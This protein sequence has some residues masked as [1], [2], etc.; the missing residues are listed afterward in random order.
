MRKKGCI[1]GYYGSVRPEKLVI[2]IKEKFGD[3]LYKAE[4]VFITYYMNKNSP[5]AMFGEIKGA[6]LMEEIEALCNKSADTML[7][8]LYDN[9]LSVGVF[10]YEVLLTGINYKE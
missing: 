7:D 5:M 4:S 8:I 1:V 2:E 6:K 3:N 10:E 9:D